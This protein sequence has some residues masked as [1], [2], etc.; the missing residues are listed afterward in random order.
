MQP[1]ASSAPPARLF[2]LDV[3]RG[4][5]IAGM[6]VANSP[7]TFGQL[8]HAWWHGLTLADLVF[9]FFIFIVGVSIALGLRKFDPQTSHK[10]PMINKILTRTLILFALGMAVNL[11]YTRF[12]SIRV[13]GVLQR[14]ALVYCACSLMGLFLSLRQITYVGIGILISYWLFILCVPAPG[15]AAG[16][17]ERDHNIVNWIDSRFLP[18]MLW[19][20]SW[21]PEGLLSTLPAIVTGMMGMLAGSIIIRS[22]DLKNTVML[23]CI[24]GFLTFTAGYIWSFF[25]P[26]NKALWSS[27]FVLVTGGLAS[28]S[29]ATLLWYTDVLGK[30]TGTYTGMVFGANAITA[31]ILHIVLDKLLTFKISG[32]SV[33]TLYQSIANAAGLGAVASATLWILLFLIVCFI[34][35]L[36]MYRKKWFVKI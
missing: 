13:A 35:I 19:R 8:S 34:P 18:G 17:L 30:R 31:Y 15:L 22:N 28:L 24:F 10:K 11:L 3:F 7:N 25:F 20:G 2:A 26:L 1:T 29:L 27:S 9:P 4:L 23:M 16:L 36:I 6:I 33:H 14:I 5:T 32:V 12:E 21:D